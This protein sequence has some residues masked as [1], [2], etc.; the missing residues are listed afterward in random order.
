M[1]NRITNKDLEYRI[2]YL[3]K[4]TGNPTTS[5]SRDSEGRFKA[6]IGNYHLMGAYG[7]VMLG[8]ITNEAG[9][10][11][12]ISNDGYDTKRKLYN[13]L[14]AYIDGI[15]LAKEGLNNA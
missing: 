4:L 12:T 11:R 15:E 2:E 3:N 8:Q 14:N 1:T 10:V 5:Y 13:F 6:N 7:G 9:G